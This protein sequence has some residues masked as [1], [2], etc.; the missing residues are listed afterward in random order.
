MQSYQ[1]IFTGKNVIFLPET[2]STN[3][4]ALELIAKT[5]PPEGTCIITDFQTDGR[6]QIGSTWYSEPGKNLLVSYIFYPKNLLAIDQFY[7]NIVISLALIG[8]L[9]DYNIS[10]KIKWPNDIYVNNRKLT[11]I[12]IQSTLVGS[13]IKATVV[14]IGLNVNQVDFIPEMKNPTS[15]AVIAGNQFDKNDVFNTLSNHLEYYYQLLIAKKFTL[16]KKLY[17]SYLYLINEIALFLDV[18]DK[19]FSGKIIGVDNQGKLM[20]KDSENEIRTYTI[21]DVKYVL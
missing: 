10:A 13:H 11:G 19:Q 1:A 4:D 20:I 12:L 2:G 9:A 8:T 17:L 16:L 18:N 5:N 6:G 21:K 15:M 14:G 7:F 3:A